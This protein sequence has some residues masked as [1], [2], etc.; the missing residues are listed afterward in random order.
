M[1][2]HWV[3]SWHQQEINFPFNS[4]SR[5]WSSFDIIETKVELHKQN[6]ALFMEKKSYFR[7]SS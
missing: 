1:K 4:S 3:S 7:I 5:A 6:P 2:I